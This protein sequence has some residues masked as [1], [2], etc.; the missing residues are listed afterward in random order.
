MPVD[1]SSHRD[2]IVEGLGR[3]QENL[4]E[5]TDEDQGS[6]ILGGPTTL[7]EEMLEELERLRRIMAGEAENDENFYRNLTAEEIVILDQFVDFFSTC[8]VCN[9]KNHRSYLQRF[10]FDTDVEK[11]RLKERLLELMEDARKFDENYYNKIVLGIPCCD[12]FKKIFFSSSPAPPPPPP[13]SY[14]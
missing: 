12:C 3:L 5:S 1:R 7:R 13:S 9:Q 14:F 8:P 6:A 10:Y 4:G 2:D 11:R